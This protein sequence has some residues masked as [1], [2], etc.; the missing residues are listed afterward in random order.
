MAEAGKKPTRT[1][2]QGKKGGWYVVGSERQQDGRTVKDYVSADVAMRAMSGKATDAEVDAAITSKPE[3]KTSK[4]ETAA[5][6]EHQDVVGREVT[7]EPDKRLPPSGTKMEPRDKS[8]YVKENKGVFTVYDTNDNPMVEG[9]TLTAALS[10]Y[11]GRPVAA[12]EALGLNQKKGKNMKKPVKP[13]NEMNFALMKMRKKLKTIMRRDAAAIPGKDGAGFSSLRIKTSDNRE[14]VFKTKPEGKGAIWGKENK[15]DAKPFKVTQEWLDSLKAEKAPS[16]AEPVK[17]KKEK[18]VAG[19]VKKAFDIASQSDSS[20]AIEI[21]TDGV[22][23]RSCVGSINGF[24]AIDIVSE[25]MDTVLKALGDDVPDNVRVNFTA[26]PRRFKKATDDTWEKDS[27]TGISKSLS[28]P[29]LLVANADTPQAFCYS[30]RDNCFI[31][32]ETIDGLCEA[33][34]IE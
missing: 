1:F 17:T 21:Y 14:F 18:T 4:K 34:G 19:E 24:M 11:E 10:Q 25:S 9:R 5:A 30:T 22:L 23:I 3:G 2:A 15:P 33:M 32:S 8:Y 31:G 28:T 13:G 12:Y 26:V 16:K 6:I 29:E 20:S 7:G 27:D